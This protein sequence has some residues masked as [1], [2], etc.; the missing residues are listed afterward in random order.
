M[1]IAFAPGASAA[2]PATVTV[3]VEGLNGVT[4]VPQTQVTTTSAPIPADGSTCSGTSAGGALY[5]AVHGNWKVKYD[6]QE[7]GYEILGLAGLTFPPFSEG[8]DAFWSFWRNGVSN[9]L[10]A[11]GQP[12]SPGDDL[13]FFAQCVKTGPDCGSATAPEHFLSSTAPSATVVQAGNPVAVTIA[14]KGTGFGAPPEGLPGGVTVSAGAV[15]A[16]PDSRGVATLVLAS[17]GIYTIQAHAPDSVPSDPQTVCVHNG[18]DGNCGTAAPGAPAPVIAP[19]TPVAQRP[20]TGPYAVIAKASGLIDGHVY[21]HGRGPRVLSGAV[22]A[23]SSISSVSIELRRSRNGR[24]YAYDGVSERFRRARCGGASFFK[25]VGG[26]TFS[27]LLPAALAPG[28]YVLDIRASDT[29]GNQAP[30]ARGSSR[31]V[32]YVR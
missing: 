25:I 18:N 6:G 5:E 8:P 13:V 19:T 10:G 30:L 32:F 26:A 29:A 31:V 14:S 15:T 11:C 22:A 9:E 17:A 24:C 7:F 2:E 20:Y 1:L 3:R 27:Y 28:R 23:H 16:A 21:A 4:L 12:L